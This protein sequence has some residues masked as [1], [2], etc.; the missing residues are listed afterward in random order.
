MDRRAGQSRRTQKGG[1]E[2][3]TASKPFRK[4]PSYWLNQ[5]LHMEVYMCLHSNSP[6]SKLPSA[7]RFWKSFPNASV[8][9]DDTRALV[10]RGGL[11]EK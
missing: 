3:E 6:S 10:H 5:Q 11:Q 8:T 2:R 9:K 4:I 7:L 1:L